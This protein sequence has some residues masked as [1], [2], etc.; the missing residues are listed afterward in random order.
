MVPPRPAPAAQGR[1]PRAL[2]C[3]LTIL[4]L[5]LLAG[6][7]VRP[8]PTAAAAT[9]RNAPPPP[10]ALAAPGP[11]RPGAAPLSVQAAIPISF[12][13]RIAYSRPAPT[14]PGIFTIGADGGSQQL[15][16]A[17]DGTSYTQPAWSPDG[18]SFAYEY[19][20]NTTSGGRIGVMG[21][22]GGGQHLITPAGA[23]DLYPAWSPDSGALAFVSDRDATHNTR[24]LYRVSAAGGALTEL[25]H[26]TLA[27][28]LGRLSWGRN[29]RIVYPSL[30]DGTHVSHI[31]TISADG[32][33]QPVRLT[34][35]TAMDSD[36]SWSGDALQIAFARFSGGVT[37][38]YLMNADGTN[39]HPVP[40]ALGSYPTWSPDQTRLAY[41][42]RVANQNQLCAINTD[43]S[44]PAQLTDDPVAAAF[45]AW[46]IGPA[47][48]HVKCSTSSRHPYPPRRSTATARCLAPPTTT[49]WSR[50][51]TPPRATR[52]SPARWSIPARP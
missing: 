51:P 6:G 8:T 11:S 36:P 46:Q 37:Q 19:Q 30:Q 25:T 38:I 20:I 27:D 28:G 45:P 15:V 34:D 12:T 48:A 13:G 2:V 31:Y 39:Q 4:A 22:Q 43:G 32:T 5:A 52:S 9:P 21:T 24:N 33:G 3:V 7:S 23:Q 1:L 40:G 18:Q 35:G 42:C 47:P 49:A 44:D 16:T 50:C 14:Y 29:N 10:A 26:F 17:L 41:I